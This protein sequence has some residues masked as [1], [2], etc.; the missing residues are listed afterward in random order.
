MKRKNT[1]QV[2]VGN[3]KIGGGADIVVQSMLNIPS[4]D[5]EGSVRQ[6]V[7]LEKAGC[8]IKLQNRYLTADLHLRQLQQ[9]LIKFVLTPAT[10]AT[11][12]G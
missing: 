9:V 1:K 2:T 12:I 5:V 7:E 6:S 11:R 4:T 3:V 8:E 10:S